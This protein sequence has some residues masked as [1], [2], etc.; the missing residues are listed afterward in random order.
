MNIVYSVA[1]AKGVESIIFC[2]LGLKRKRK[3][4]H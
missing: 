2:H 1:I 4:K 3:G